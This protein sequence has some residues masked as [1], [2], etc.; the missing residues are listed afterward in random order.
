VVDLNK[1]LISIL[2]QVVLGLPTAA[3]LAVDGSHYYNE[4]WSHA[5][6]F[7]TSPPLRDDPSVPDVIAAAVANDDYQVS[8]DYHKLQEH[9]IALGLRE[10]LKNVE[11]I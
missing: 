5:A 10:A 7:V 3:S 11:I 6:A 4:C 2:F 9:A 8:E 1:H